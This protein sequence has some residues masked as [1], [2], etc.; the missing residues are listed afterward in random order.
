MTDALLPEPGQRIR[1]HLDHWDHDVPS[2]VDERLGDDVVVTHP[3]VTADDEHPA[4]DVPSEGT[5]VTVGWATPIGWN[6]VPTSVVSILGDSVPRWWLRP[7]G[8]VVRL[9]RRAFARAAFH[10]PAVLEGGQA[11]AGGSVV[12]LGEGGLRCAVEWGT[13]VFQPG[14]TVTTRITF[15]DGGLLALSAVVVR[16]QSR[17]AGREIAVRFVDVSSHDAD[18]IRHEVFEAERRHQ[19]EKAEEE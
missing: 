16:A 8:A 15:D 1:L 10:A 14:E 17:A 2:T 9:Q 4:V 11:S 7:T 12:D 18:R 13:P 6:E 5:L 3:M 19:T